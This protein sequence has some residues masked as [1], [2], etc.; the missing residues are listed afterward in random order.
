ML[1]NSLLQTA[2]APPPYICTAIKFIAD[3]LSVNNHEPSNNQFSRDAQIQYG[4][5][6]A[7]W[8]RFRL[9]P[10]TQE[11]WLLGSAC[12][13]S[14]WRDSRPLTRRGGGRADEISITISHLLCSSSHTLHLL[15]TPLPPLL[16]F[17]GVWWLWAVLRCSSL[18]CGGEEERG[19]KREAAAHHYHV[20][21]GPLPACLPAPPAAQY[22]CGSAPDPD[23]L[24]SQVCQRAKRRVCEASSPLFVYSSLGEP[25]TPATAAKPPQWCWDKI[26][27]WRWPWHRGPW[28]FSC[29]WNS[30][31]W[32]WL[33]Q[34]LW[35]DARRLAGALS[36]CCSAW[37]PMV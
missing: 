10:T 6:T 8:E 2:C 33:Q 5:D 13:S 26:Y 29:P 3:L 19:R 31:C 11:S 23:Q 24:G 21:R 25:Q 4:V 7:V 35:E 22:S 20:P 12:T 30:P 37:S 36:P 17:W 1:R 27:F 28:C 9:H 16:A 34:P 18:C 32:A 14:C 15:P